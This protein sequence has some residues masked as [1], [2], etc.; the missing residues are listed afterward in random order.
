[1]FLK[2][3]RYSLNLTIKKVIILAISLIV[4]SALLG[5]GIG[6]MALSSNSSN[7]PVFIVIASTLFTYVTWIAVAIIPTI[8]TWYLLIGT[9]RD[10]ASDMAYLT[11]TLPIKAKDLIFSKTLSV[12]LQVVLLRVA[13]M[14]GV[15]LAIFLGVIISGVPIQDFFV[16]IT[17]FIYEMGLILTDSVWD[18]ITLFEFGIIALLADLL[19]IIG[20]IL[21]ALLALNDKKRLFAIIALVIVGGYFVGVLL[22]FVIA[23]IFNYLAVSMVELTTLTIQP[24]III[25]ILVL[26]LIIFS[27]YKIC[28]NKIN[29]GVNLK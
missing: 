11:F 21:V 2:S 12:F 3:F 29:K 15:C 7:P 18:V 5:V 20:T 6:V 23:S 27:I 9:H 24:F 4:A 25:V 10:F 13:Q 17:E 16:L 14:V 28:E 8:F 1:M 22:S 26:L 19:L